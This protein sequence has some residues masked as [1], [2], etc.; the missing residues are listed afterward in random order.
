MKLKTVWVATFSVMPL[1]I[2][3]WATADSV[4]SPMPL[5]VS[6]NG[7][8]GSIASAGDDGSR[9]ASMELGVFATAEEG[10]ATDCLFQDDA[11]WVACQDPQELRG[12]R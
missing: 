7:G 5:D 1:S 6:G 4:F 3:G 8:V 9:V 12:A 2:C 10:E 11:D